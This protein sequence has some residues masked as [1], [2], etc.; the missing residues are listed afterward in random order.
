MKLDKPSAETRE[1]VRLIRSTASSRYFDNGADPATAG[2]L[3][4]HVLAADFAQDLS[5]FPDSYLL[6]DQVTDTRIVETIQRMQETVN[7]KADHTIPL[8]AVIEFAPAIEVDTRRPPKGQRD[9]LMQTLEDEL[10]ARLA[11]LATEARKL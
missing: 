2:E 6:P 1:R 3:K 8:K 10:T 4:R 7:G 11:R 5:S 9:P